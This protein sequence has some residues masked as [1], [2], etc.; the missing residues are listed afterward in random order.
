MRWAPDAERWITRSPVLAAIATVGL[1]G[2]PLPGRQPTATRSP[3]C[4]RADSG[5]TAAGLYYECAGTGDDVMI[6]IPAFSMDLRMWEGQVAWLEGAARVIAYD[7]RGHGKSAAPSAPYSAVDDLL[8]L[9]DEL[10]VASAT[11]IGLSNGARVALDFALSHPE[12]VRAMVLAGPGVSGYVSSE[13]MTWM[14]PVISA[15]RAGD[16]GSA[17]ERW[18][19]TP[20]MHIPGDS[21]AAARV[22][23]LSQD[24]RAIWGYRTNPEI[25]LD[26]PAIGR[27]GKVKVPV[28][29]VSGENDMPNLRRL[30]DSV[31]EGIPRAKLVVIPGAGHMVNLAAPAEFDAAV[32]AFLGGLSPPR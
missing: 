2:N 10:R 9:M 25:P 17:A 24:N 5:H 12:R 1:S 16:L 18:A 13:P 26:P 7:L 30:A 11:L 21:A 28:L 31:V 23:A 20:L 14:E 15:V 32:R 27:L 6:L 4:V 19:E 3:A 22:R 8:G 29:V